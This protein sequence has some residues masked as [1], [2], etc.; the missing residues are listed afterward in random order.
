MEP[1]QSSYSNSCPIT[2][3]TSAMF[4]DDFQATSSLNTSSDNMPQCNA[5]TM[6]HLHLHNNQNYLKETT[7]GR[8]ND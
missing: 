8:R 6:L 1:D 3:S 5:T 7:E 2:Q 4:N